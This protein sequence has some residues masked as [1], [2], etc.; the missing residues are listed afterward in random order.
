MQN[1]ATFLTISIAHTYRIGK[2]L[3]RPQ[4]LSRLAKKVCSLNIGPLTTQI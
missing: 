3:D 4:L 2:L 1:S